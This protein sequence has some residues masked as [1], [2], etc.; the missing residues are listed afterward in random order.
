MTRVLL[1]ILDGFGL[2]KEAPN[3]AISLA[4]M[5]TFTHLK[6]TYP[7]CTLL[8]GG[9]EVGLPKGIVG[10]SEVGHMNLG[11]G[12]RV[13]QDFV[14]INESIETK[15]LE[16]REEFLNL[17][18]YL[19]SLPKNKRRLHL[20]GLISDGGVHSHLDHVKEIIRLCSQWEDVSVWVHGFSDG[21]DTPRQNGLLYF[22]ELEEWGQKIMKDRFALASIHGR[23]FGMDRDRRWEKIKASYEVMVGQDL[24]QSKKEEIKK[25]TSYLQEQYSKNCFDEHIPPVLLKEEGAIQREDAVFFMN[26]RP[27][28]AIELTQCFCL[29]NF[30]FF[31]RDIMPAY[32][33]CMVPYI[34]DE[35]SLPIL[36]DKEKLE[37]PLSEILSTQG[38]RQFKIA[39]TEKYA[40]VTY[41]FN[42]GKR[43]PFEGET[44]VLVPSPKDVS[45]YDQK[46]EMSAREVSQKLTEAMRRVP[47]EYDFFLVN[48]A[49]PDMVGHTG[50]LTAAIKA[51]EVV[52]ECLFEIYQVCKEH[53]IQWIITADHGNC[54]EMTY[55]DGSIHTAHSASP[56]PFI[57]VDLEGEKTGN[58]K[59]I[60][61]R[62]DSS[63]QDIAPTILKLFDL[64]IPSVMTGT[65]LL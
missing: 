2:R 59:K 36:F 63:L 5:P 46:P 29:P 32:F 15:Q 20:I 53:K 7:F 11:A 56:V 31:K 51:L 17:K 13:R 10:N 9:E 34:P 42:G 47:S 1:T 62:E 50:N 45:S 14:R 54:E 58:K 12:R 35:M 37:L 44:H 43:G 41:F 4:K 8:P 23:S 18:N 48:F 16:K 27:D 28:R 52:D 40:H 57:F 19:L 21:R 49:N 33:L 22:Q 30:S 64:P 3:N 25:A 6:K 65:S 39:E 26:F 60:Y 55:E 61:H 38:L 24:E